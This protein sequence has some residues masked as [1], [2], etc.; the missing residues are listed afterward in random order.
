MTATKY[1]LNHHAWLKQ[2]ESNLEDMIAARK[3]KLQMATVSN[4][5]YDNIEGEIDELSE[6]L[7][8]IQLCLISYGSTFQIN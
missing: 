4:G 1:N 6:T 7:Q 2:I 5:E 8:H 3:R